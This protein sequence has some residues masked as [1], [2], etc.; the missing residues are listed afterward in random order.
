MMALLEFREK[1]RQFYGRYDA[2]VMPFLKFGV[3]LAVFW[4]L[5]SNVGYMDKLKSPA[6]LFLLSAVCSFLPYGVISF[7]AGIVLVAHISSVSLEMALILAVLLV[8]MAVLYYGFQPGDSYLLLLTPIF[9]QMKIPYVIPI[10]V[11][12]SGGLASKVMENQLDSISA[13][14]LG[15]SHLSKDPQEILD[16]LKNASKVLDGMK[17]NV[18]DAYQQLTGGKQFPE[19]A[20]STSIFS[21]KSSFDFFASQMETDHRII[22]TAHMKLTGQTLR[23]I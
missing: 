23:F 7:F 18:E 8:M 5:N 11:G 10:L 17:K 9:F 13:A 2:V 15:L 12:L 1:L 14:S 19:P 21:G 4:L 6:V 16:A 3:S 22:D 20:R